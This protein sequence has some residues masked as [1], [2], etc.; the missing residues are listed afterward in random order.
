MNI[1]DFND[2]EKHRTSGALCLRD[3]IR[4]KM[5]ERLAETMEYR[6]LAK[7]ILQRLSSRDEPLE[8]MTDDDLNK[9]KKNQ[10]DENKVTLND[11][12]QLKLRV[13]ANGITFSEMNTI[14]VI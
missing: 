8:N 14:Q 7:N 10:N 12:N 5:E 11:I 3:D 6:Q 2:I 9:K 13:K 1:L 4:I